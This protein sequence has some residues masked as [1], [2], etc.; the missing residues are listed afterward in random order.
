MD[1][2]F[3]DEQIILD[4]AVLYSSE[5]KSGAAVEKNRYDEIVKEYGRLLKQLRR[6]TK[7][8]D[9][10]SGN[11]NTS[12]HDLLDKVHFDALTGIYNRRFMEDSLK[13]IIKSLARSGGILSLMMIDIDY[14]KKYN[15]TYGHSDGDV[16]LKAVAET[17]KGS[18]FRADD[19]VARYGGE[20]FSVV[21]PDT[22]ESGAR[23]IAEKILEN[24]R[25]RS[26]PHEKNEVA[27][28]VTV[29]IGIT[30]SDVEHGHSWGEYIKQADKALYQSKQNGRNRYTFINFEE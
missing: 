15:D 11:L 16:C 23:M 13:R 27:G 29:S 18:L 30:T 3:S 21:L 9:R 1:D 2:I 28:H 6:V 26:I 8:S 19:F 22:D 25:T 10:A 5:L 14:F 17:L 4:N 24:V 7:L 12:K 20:E